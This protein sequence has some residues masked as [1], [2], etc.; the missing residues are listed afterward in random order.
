[1][2]AAGSCGSNPRPQALHPGC[3]RRTI[4]RRSR[5]Q[6]EGTLRMPF[7]PHTDD[8]EREILATIGA[9]SIEALFD[10]IP[11]SLRVQSLEGLPAGLSELEVMQLMA[12]RARQDGRALCFIG[13]GAYEHH[14]PAAVWSTITR[15]EF[16]SA[17]TPYQAEASQ[18]TL[19][20][21]YEYQ[22]MMAGLTGMQVSNASLYD[23]ATAVAEACLMAVRANRRSKAARILLPRAM[24]PHYR[25]VALTTASN[26][27]LQFEELPYERGAGD[28][29]V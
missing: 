11:A 16:Y 4:T 19:Q 18:G 12:A 22:S 5:P 24:H 27:S 1:M 15:G 10:E 13:A 29:A 7:I 28:T 14:I 9:P 3:C 17:Y 23:G 21:I 8:D 20:S 25:A 26:Q 6:A 2:G